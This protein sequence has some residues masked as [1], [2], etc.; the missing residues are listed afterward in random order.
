MGNV[1][2][3]VEENLAEDQILWRYMDLSK[4]ISLLEKN[5]L[6]LARADTF[7][8][9]HEGR[10]PYD[11]RKLI[12]KAYI[13]FE[14][15]DKPL[16]KNVDDFQDFLRKNTFI[17]CWHKNFDESMVMWEI[18]GKGTDAIAI[19]TTVEKFKDSIDTSNIAGHS[20]KLNNVIYKSADEISEVLPYEDCFFIKR[21]HFSYE[22]EVRISLDTYSTNNP[23]KKKPYGYYLPVFLNGFIEKILIHPDSPGWYM[24]AIKSIIVK[25]EIHAP[26]VRGLYGTN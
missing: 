1:Y 7:R 15:E 20:L 9:K 4:F 18:Y 16:I 10:L 26:I 22:E 13:D 24:D 5:A 2:L 25:Y 21:P 11:M 3:E 14:K 8:D 12:D 23:T 6:W 17:N 19:Q